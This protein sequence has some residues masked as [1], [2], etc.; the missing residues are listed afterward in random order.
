MRKFGL[1]KLYLLVSSFFIFLLH[2]PFVFAKVEPS[3]KK[4]SVTPSLA[5]KTVVL[6]N[7]HS[8]S[9]P[10]I[11]NVYDSLSLALK[12]LSRQ[13]FDYAI[14]GLGYMK[15]IGKL[16]NESIISIVDFSKPSSQKRL[17]IIDL[18][19]YRLLFNTYVAHGANSGKEYANQFSNRPESYMSS[20]GF[21][22]TAETYIGKHGYS[23]HLQG[24]ERGINDNAY[25]R[26]IVI[27]GAD[28]VNDQYVR[29][30]GYIGRSWGCPAVPEKLSKPIIDKIKNGT[31]LFI[32]SPNKN[33]LAQSQIIR[34]SVSDDLAYNN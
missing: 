16:T 5:G 10:I 21:Y 12:G 27:H 29:L 17:F 18:K 34:H 33:Y 31:C 19:N 24:L 13:A 25:M 32:F 9:T 7:D 3:V 4:N 6:G 20:L 1:K 30:Q 8:A 28:Y 23:L 26:D 22:K 14:Q 11:A 2:L 15:G